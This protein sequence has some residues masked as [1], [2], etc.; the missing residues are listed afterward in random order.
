[1]ILRYKRRAL[2][3]LEGIHDYISQ[4]DAAAAK[5]VIAHIQHSV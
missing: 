2:R 1:M 4:F 5:R 3:D